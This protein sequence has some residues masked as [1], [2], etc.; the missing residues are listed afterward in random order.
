MH[1]VQQVAPDK[2]TSKI[3]S[4]IKNNNTTEQNDIT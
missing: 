2:N 3:N 4:I 1:I